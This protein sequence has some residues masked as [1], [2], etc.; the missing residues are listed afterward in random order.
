MCWRPRLSTRSISPSK[1]VFEF[2]NE[3][4]LRR[5]DRVGLRNSLKR[6]LYFWRGPHRCIAISIELKLRLLSKSLISMAED[7][8]R[9]GYADTVLW[10]NEQTTE[11]YQRG[12]MLS[13]DASE[14]AL[15]KLFRRQLVTALSELFR[16]LGTRS[17]MSVFR[18][19]K[20][21]GYLSSF[22]HAGRYYTLAEVARF[23]QWGL[24]FH[25]G[26]G[27]S[28]AGTLKATVLELVEG[29]SGGMT[30]KE[31]LALLKLPVANSLYNTLHELVDSG[32]VR[33][34]KL[35]GLHLYLSA[36]EEQAQQQVAQ[37][38]RETVSQLPPP[39]QASA[40]M[41]IAVLVEALQAEDD[42]VAA[43][44]VADRLKA[45]GVGVTAAQVEQVFAHYGLAPEKKT[46]APGSRPSRNSDR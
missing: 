36:A 17:R 29:S 38:Q 9:L 22:T 27:F 23:D 33:R 41:V 2:S 16:A 35:T 8:T 30:P 7:V 45:R 40:E 42:L 13:P 32:R 1:P 28:R 12:L 21:L 43:S 25:R 31:I 20:A 19:L 4:G 39:P 44:V 26:V 5:H 34:Q 3:N 14:E 6:R 11:L 37:R 24:W 15:R 10:F 18:R 46:A